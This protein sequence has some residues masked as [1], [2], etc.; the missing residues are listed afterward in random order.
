MSHRKLKWKKHESYHKY[1]NSDS[2]PEFHIYEFDCGDGTMFQL[3]FS[4]EQHF[5]TLRAAKEWVEDF[6][7]WKK[8]R[9]EK[10]QTNVDKQEETK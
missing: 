8:E 5:E 10:E 7:K 4:H 1:Y 6:R 3:T 2:L 9:R